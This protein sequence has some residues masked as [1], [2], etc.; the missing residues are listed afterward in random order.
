MAL[1]EFEREQTSERVK[2]ATLARS[3]R[4]LWNGGHVLGY[5]L[6]PER[7]GH[8]IPNEKEKALVNFAFDA[9]L[10]QGSI[11]STAK[12]MNSN[13]Y[14]T[15]VYTTHAGRYHPPQEFSYSSIKNML[16]NY[17]YIG[18]KEINKKAR[19]KGQ[20]QLPDGEQY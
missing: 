9:Y 17:T 1:A 11:L 10:K 20:S 16:T 13:G 4:G 8:I 2:E 6:N 18:R 5:D 15:K 19:N 12:V 14:R 7:K 3:L